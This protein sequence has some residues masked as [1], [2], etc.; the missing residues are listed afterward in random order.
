VEF[1]FLRGDGGALRDCVAVVFVGHHSALVG[2]FAI[3]EEGTEA[4]V[5]SRHRLC[6]ILK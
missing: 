1:E 2:W 6:K 4:T 5:V 3:G